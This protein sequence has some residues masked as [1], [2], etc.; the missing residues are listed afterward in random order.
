[1]RRRG[2]RRAPLRFV[3]SLVALAFGLEEWL[4]G[5]DRWALPHAVHAERR[6][7]MVGG[8]PVRSFEDGCA[9]GAPLLLVHSL[10]LF[11]S[12]Y[13]M[14][15]LFELFRHERPVAALDLPG[16]GSSSSDI[17]GYGPKILTSALS[18][19]IRDLSAR[20]G[21]RVDVVAARGSAHLAWS[22]TLTAGEHVRSITL[23]G[24]TP[25]VTSSTPYLPALPPA[26]GVSL[27]R[28]LGTRAALR[29][30]LRRMFVGDVDESFVTHAARAARVRG[31]WGPA[32]TRLRGALTPLEHSRR[33]PLK[34][35]VHVVRDGTMLDP[36]WADALRRLPS[37]ED[38]HLV[39]LRGL[40]HY[41][42]ACSV[43]RA[44]R[45]FLRDLDASTR[46][47]EDRDRTSVPRLR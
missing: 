38:S 3:S 7:L 22:S 21:S 10:E 27:Y 44:M 2:T 4:E 9:V 34:V 28:L 42:F 5:W 16:F 32:A 46:R 39:T 37:W 23:V 12:S 17:P 35:P 14:R 18:A 20:Y 36:A 6:T 13:E 31:A 19:T 1:M 29:W 41:E 45:P 8:M 15:R 40:L 24:P 33:R 25:T 26:A 30:Y 43:A 47:R 11:A